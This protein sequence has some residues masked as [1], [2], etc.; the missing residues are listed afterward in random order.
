MAICRISIRAIEQ[1]IG[2]A[3]ESKILAGSHPPD[4]ERTMPD[5]TG[6]CWRRPGRR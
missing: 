4:P 3:K 6:S 1:F 5:I 2:E